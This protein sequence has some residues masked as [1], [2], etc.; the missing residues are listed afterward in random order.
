MDLQTFIAETLQQI[1]AG[2]KEAQS[3]KGGEAINAQG[4]GITGG[5]LFSGA[6]DAGT[7]WIVG[8]CVGGV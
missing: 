4:G 1:C 7:R 6:A 2:I 3:A 8:T 5:N